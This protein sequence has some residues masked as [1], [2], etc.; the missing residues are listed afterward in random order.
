MALKAL[1][2]VEKQTER[3]TKKV[4]KANNEKWMHSG[5][6]PGVVEGNLVRP[7]QTKS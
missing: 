1:L 6:P 3:Q 7:N 2:E 4:Q 5:N